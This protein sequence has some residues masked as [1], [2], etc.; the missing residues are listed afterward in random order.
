MNRKHRRKRAKDDAEF[1]RRHEVYL[2]TQKGRSRS[3]RGQLEEGERI[4]RKAL[5]IDPLNRAALS[6]LGEIYLR[7]KDFR[8]A[9]EVLEQLIS[10][11][12][13]G[14][15]TLYNLAEAYR[16]IQ[17]RD[18]ACKTLERLVER[19]P[20]HLQG[21]TR[22]GDAFLARKDY[23]RAIELYGRALDRSGENIFALRGIGMAY[24]G[25]KMYREAIDAWERLLRITPRDHRILVRMGDALLREG[26]R[27]QAHRAYRLA[28]E[29]VPGNTYALQGMARIRGDSTS[30]SGG[31]S[32]A[33]P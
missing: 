9:A 12:P 4:F 31:R 20:D 15:R 33:Q 32:S 21:L 11:H 19:N 24:R 7:R 18:K 5:A 22:L 27:S 29:I 23:G 6:G 10:V 26:E 17:R 2:L 3:R 25:R 30:A 1:L 16:G 14:E 8:E 28:L 13:A